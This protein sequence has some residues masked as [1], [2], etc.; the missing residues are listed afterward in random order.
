[1]QAGGGRTTRVRSLA[2][3]AVALAEL[4]LAPATAEARDCGQMTADGKTWAVSQRDT[5]CRFARYA[6]QLYAS[7]GRAPAN[8]RC[9]QSPA[10]EFGPEGGWQISCWRPQTERR[11]W[12]EAPA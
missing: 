9:R 10:G 2:V 11:A 7:Q 6:V 1:M 8:W 4:V 3:A 12:G 5:N